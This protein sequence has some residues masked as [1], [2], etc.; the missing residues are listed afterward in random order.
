M[1]F[2][3]TEVPNFTRDQVHDHLTAALEVCDA[4]DLTPEDRAVL[5]PVVFEKLSS[6][7][8]V[9]E[10]LQEVTDLNSLLRRG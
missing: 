9:I 2:N 6:K 8:V 7:Q 1:A 4:H 10:Q 5:L 3:R